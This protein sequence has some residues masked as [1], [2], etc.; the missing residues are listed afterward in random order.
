MTSTLIGYCHRHSDFVRRTQGW[1]SMHPRLTPSVRAR[2]RAMLPAVLVAMTLMLTGTAWALS[3]P[4]GSS[5]DDDFHLASIWCAWGG[6]PGTCD[7]RKT[8]PNQEVAFVAID[9][10]RAPC[11]AYDANKSG[12]CSFGLSQR[13]VPARINNDRGYPGL[14][15]TAMRL[16]VR[17]SVPESVLTMRIVNLLLASVMLGATIAVAT[18]LLR[19]AVA[20]SWLSTLVPLTLFFVPSTNPTSW[21]LIGLGTYWALL[22]RFLTGPAGWGRRLAG[23]LA[24]VSAVITAGARADGAAFLCV[25]TVAVAV[26]ALPHPRDLLQPRMALAAVVV[27]GSVGV[28]LTTG[29]S[30][31]LGGIGDSVPLPGRSGL[32]LLAQNAYNYPGL[33]LGVFGVGWGLG[34]LDTGIPSS[35][36]ALATAIPFALL[37]L[38][39]S[40]FWRRKAIAVTLVALPILILPLYIL[41]SGGNVV[42][43]NVQPRYLLPLVMV[44]LGLCLLGRGESPGGWSV[45]GG[46]L[47]LL[48]AAATI[49]NLM[50]LQANTRRYVTG[51]DLPNFDLDAGR[52]WWWALPFGAMTNWAVG[53]AAG[54]ALFA[55]LAFAS[56]LPDNSVQSRARPADKS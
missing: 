7:I 37:V 13:E 47:A 51:V 23:G 48:A 38:S 15:Y 5:P 10:V 52:E 21:V 36:G 46:G 42:G 25:I 53:S 50:A 29:Q 45:G 20:L 14:F 33:L 26:L 6:E 55:A 56:R 16:F 49:A 27:L 1:G 54:L 9:V 3:S 18:P 40:T 2:I 17:D 44:G 8:G 43:E 32:T 35:A 12:A 11:F 22:L 34:W 41:Q 30:G 31:A 19:R 39:S 4:A 28:F 24:L